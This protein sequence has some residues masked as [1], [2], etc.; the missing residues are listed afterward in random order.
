MLLW[1]LRNV[2]VSVEQCCLGWLWCCWFWFSIRL[3]WRVWVGGSWYVM[4]QL[5]DIGGDVMVMC[6]VSVELVDLVDWDVKFLVFNSTDMRSVSGWQLLDIGGRCECWWRRGGASDAG[7]FY[8][9]V[10]LWGH[11]YWEEMWASDAGHWG[12]RSDSDSHVFLQGSPGLLQGS[13]GSADKYK[14]FNVEEHFI[15]G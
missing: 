3:G 14:T 2:L 8:W 5:L 4:G 13:L 11:L 1:L 12:Q 7:W 10:L 9:E 15:L 6:W